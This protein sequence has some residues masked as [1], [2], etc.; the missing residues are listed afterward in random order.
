MVIL[1]QLKGL[2]TEA[3]IHSSRLSPATEAAME[4]AV[5]AA[6]ARL[7]DEELARAVQQE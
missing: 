5:E 1:K 6:A 2:P 3:L 4:A 7:S